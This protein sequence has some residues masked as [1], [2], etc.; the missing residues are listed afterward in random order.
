M[1]Y[2]EPHFPPISLGRRAAAAYVPLC[3]GGWQGDA[4][5]LRDPRVGFCCA[6]RLQSDAVVL[7]TGDD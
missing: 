3:P 4:G 7:G 2:F 6:T 5:P 1:G